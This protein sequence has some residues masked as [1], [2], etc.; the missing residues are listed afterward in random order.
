MTVLVA[1]ALLSA[2]FIPLLSAETVMS[3]LAGLAGL[4]GIWLRTSHLPVS[5]AEQNVVLVTLMGL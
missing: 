5:E 2:G 4:A 3:V 1:V